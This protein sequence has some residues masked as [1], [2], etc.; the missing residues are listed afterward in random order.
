[1]IKSYTAFTREIDDAELAISE[2]L[3]QLNFEAN[4][5]T[6]TIGLVHFYYEF[7]ETDICQ[8]LIEAL[9]FPLAGCVSSYTAINGEYDDV[10]LSVTM[11]TS[12][13]VSFTV[14][15]IEEIDTKTREQVTDEVSAMLTK[16]GEKEKP[17]LI[18]PLLSMMKN[19]SGDDLVDTANALDDTYP[20]FGTIAFN[21][22]NNEGTHYVLANDKL[23][24]VMCAFIAFYGNFEPK[25]HFTSSFAFDDSFGDVAEITKAEGALL[26]EVNHIPALSYLK[27]LGMVSADDSVAAG[28]IWAVPA[29]LNFPNGTKVV[30]AFLGIVEGT[31][32]IFA[33]GALQNGAKIQFAYLDGDKTLGS[34]K[35]LFEEK[36]SGNESN[37]LAFSCA[38][39]AW[40][41]GTKFFAEAQT[42]A[43][44][45][46]ESHIYS[47]AYSGGEF[48]P[49]ID[50]S[51]K[52]IN[53]LHNYTLITCSLH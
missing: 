12:D 36:D 41:L 16:L 10:A 53:T 29:I 28:G 11:L 21:M 52:L 37:F 31:E 14:E 1:M 43:S 13:D 8:A 22:E 44:Y 6:N 50:N 34:A 18:I 30:R 15:T 3:K 7:A 24:S 35:K 51:G 2:I 27:K 40:S 32:S 23:S 4:S 45:A 19:Y 48:C 39:R 42:I 46:D 33:T 5:L 17:K 20:L 9:P 47:L 49:V 26:H 38:A 25:F